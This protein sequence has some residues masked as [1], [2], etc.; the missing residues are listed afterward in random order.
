M[1]DRRT[2]LLDRCDRAATAAEARFR[3]DAPNSTGRSSRVI[4]L[5]AGAERIVEALARGSWNGARF[6]VHEEGAADESDS[7]LRVPGDA[8]TTTL[9]DELEGADVVVMVATDEADPAAA[10]AVGRAAARRRIMT[11]GLVVADA[12]SDGRAL[13]ALRPYAAVLVVSPDEHYIPEMLTALR[14]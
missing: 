2:T 10:S 5:D 4:A 8:S 13:Q 3:I 11:A 1:A 7:V 9:S 14:A 6:L 12:D